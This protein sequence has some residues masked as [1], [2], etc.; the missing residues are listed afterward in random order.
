[1]ELTIK[2]D[3]SNKDVRALLKYLKS[4]SIVEVIE[5][6]TTTPSDLLRQAMSEIDEEKTK[7]ID[8]KDELSKILE[9]AK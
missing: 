8:G 9:N 6:E 5:K 7:T 4:L 2:M 3:T 1:M